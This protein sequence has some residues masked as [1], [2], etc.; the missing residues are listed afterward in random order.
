MHVVNRIPSS[1]NARPHVSRNAFHDSPIA[2]AF[3][4]IVVD[5]AIP[6][7]EILHL[8]PS[9]TWR[10]SHRDAAF[11]EGIAIE[12]SETWGARKGER[13]KDF[14]ALFFW[15]G[16][17]LTLQK[18]PKVNFWR[19][20]RISSGP[21]TS[22]PHPPPPKET[23]QKL[24]YPLANDNVSSTARLDHVPRASLGNQVPALNFCLLLGASLHA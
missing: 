23:M 7:P 13:P 16:P 19:P 17:F 4:A 6:H 20:W 14:S 21:W 18:P 11:L 5:C 22:V 9:P 2:L 3:Q 8:T 15:T 10:G 1:P 24:S 12:P